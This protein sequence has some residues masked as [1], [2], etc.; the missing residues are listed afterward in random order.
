M[1]KMLVPDP[2]FYRNGMHMELET[3]I[4]ARKVLKEIFAQQHIHS[5]CD[6]RS[7]QGHLD[8]TY[9]RVGSP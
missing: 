2:K 7:K 1:M 8:A 9:S 4:R 6:A 3:H 5:A